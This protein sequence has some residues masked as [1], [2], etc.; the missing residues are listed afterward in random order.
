VS[1]TGTQLVFNSH[2]PTCV[3]FAPLTGP[4]HDISV[5]YIAHNPPLS[6]P[7]RYE[8]FEERWT[9]ST[10]SPGIQQTDAPGLRAKAEAH[11][12]GL[13]RFNASL[14]NKLQLSDCLGHRVS[15]PGR[16]NPRH[17]P[18]APNRAVLGESLYVSLLPASLG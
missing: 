17:R 6:L 11:R 5:R 16:D 9:R 15:A 8:I 12:P 13:S 7:T 1:R 18:S 14:R 4:N 3:E 10:S 2:S